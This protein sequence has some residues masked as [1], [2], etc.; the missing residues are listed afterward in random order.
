MTTLQFV[1]LQPQLSNLITE[2]KEKRISAMGRKK[3]QMKK[4]A[5]K[6]SRYVTFSKRRSGLFKKA[7]EIATLCAA[8]IAIIVFSPT[9]KP[10]S[11]G[12][13]S[14]EAV[15][16]RFLNQ[17]DRFAA[18]EIGGSAQAR[19]LKALS[20]QLDRLNA[21]VKAE[22][23]KG[24]RLKT[25]MAEETAVGEIEVAEMHKL[26]EMLEKI[27]EAASKKM[28]EIESEASNTLLLLSNSGAD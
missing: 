23:E 27:R 22:K 10:F 12:Q 16:D 5:D 26:K 25:A 15:T 20:Q 4:I 3:V 17:D 6:N 2:G 18:G 13:P 11:F 8:Q 9:G 7:A 14:A 28:S 1:H 19:E 21:Q 24:E